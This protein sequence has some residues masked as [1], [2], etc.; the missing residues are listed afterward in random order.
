MTLNSDETGATYSATGLDEGTNTA[1]ITVTDAS[2]ND[3]TAT[4]SW[5]FIVDLDTTPPSITSTSPVGIIR[6]EKP[7]IAVTVND[8]S[9]VDSVSVSLDG[10]VD[11]NNKTMGLDETSATY[12]VTNSLEEGTY[13]V[14][15]TA[16]DDSANKNKATAQWSF[17]VEFD[18]DPPE[19]SIVSPAAGSRITDLKPKIIAN[20]SDA[21]EIDEDSVNFTITDPTGGCLICATEGTTEIGQNKVSYERTVE[22][23]NYGEYT[24][25]LEVSDIHGNQAVAEWSFYVESAVASIEVPR[26]FPNPFKIEDGT[27]IAFT[28]TKQARVTIKIYD[29]TSR[30]VV[31]P[32]ED[33]M[34]ASGPQKVT[35][36]AKSENGDEFAKGVYFCQI[37]ADGDLKTEQAVIKMAL[38][39]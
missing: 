22:L 2:A 16:T 3:N 21:S 12:E 25:E 18:T 5:S 11:I 37:I 13:N 14:T 9:G 1:E 28:L 30:L 26:N 38:F 39:R 10:P 20:Y 29:M 23:E 6:D 33:E 19:I 17:T 32:V 4:Y 7:M 8:E 34:M 36:D 35:W 27:T 15:V 24:I 31:K